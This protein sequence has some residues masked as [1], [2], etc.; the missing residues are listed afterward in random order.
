MEYTS[1]LRIGKIAN[2]GK[3]RDGNKER[4][5]LNSL[6]GFIATEKSISVYSCVSSKKDTRDPIFH[7]QKGLK[8]DN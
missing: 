8:I 3:E 6:D 5:K 7:R 1:N 4:E 2:K